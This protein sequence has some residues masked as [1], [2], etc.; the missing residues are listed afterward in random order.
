[1]AAS[2]SVSIHRAGLARET[3]HFDDIPEHTHPAAEIA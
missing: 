3:Q 1:M 2:R